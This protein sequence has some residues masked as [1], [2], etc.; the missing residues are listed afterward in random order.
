[1]KIIKKQ[2]WTTLVFVAF[3]SITNAQKASK[4]ISIQPSFQSLSCNSM[5][6]PTAIE[7]D[8]PLFSWVI[9]ANGF[10]KSQSAYHILSLQVRIN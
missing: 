3:L 5:T 2:V 8:N 4:P 1:M 10:N 9:K 7:S 6:N